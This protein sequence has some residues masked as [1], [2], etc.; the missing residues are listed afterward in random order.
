MNL[1]ENELLLS[2]SEHRFIFCGSYAQLKLY[3]AGYSS[4]C[5]ERIPWTEI[6]SSYPR[7]LCKKGPKFR[8][9]IKETVDLIEFGSL[10]LAVHIE[11][12]K[13]KIKGVTVKPKLH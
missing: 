3:L 2:S 1:C 9:V 6:W 4:T 10:K 8:V 13:G 12:R 5:P 7:K 11:I